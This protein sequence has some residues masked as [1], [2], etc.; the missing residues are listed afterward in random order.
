MAHDIFISYAAQDKA[1]ADAVCNALEGAKMRC[2]I[3]PRDIRSGEHWAESINSAIKVSRV[4]VLIFSKDSNHS[5]QIAKELTLAINSKAIIV[6]FKIDDIVPSGIIEYYLSDTHW[7]D[8][9]N[10]P[11]ESQISNLVET[12]KHALSDKTT[13]ELQKIPEIKFKMGPAASG[14]SKPASDDKKKPAYVNLMIALIGVF[15]V[16]FA[17]YALWNIGRIPE[18]ILEPDDEI[19]N[20]IVRVEGNSAGNLVNGGLAAVQGDI[21]IFRS[22]DGYSLHKGNLV[23]GESRVISADS[24]WFIN[25]SD[26]WIYYSNRDDSNRVYKIKTDGSSRAVLTDGGALFVTYVD[27]WIYYISE[28]DNYGIYRI[29]IDGNGKTLLTEDA[30]EFI[31]VSDGWVYYVNRSEGDKIYRIKVDGSNRE[32]VNETSSCCINVYENDW[33]YYVNKEDGS[34]LY[35]MRIDGRENTVLNDHPTW[36]LNV[37]SGWVYYANENDNFSLN[38]MDLDGNFKMQLSGEPVRFINVVDNWVFY[39]DQKAED[40]VYKVKTDGT[41]RRLAEDSF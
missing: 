27:E 38:R 11:T 22:N 29:S 17:A 25:I 6:P 33:I 37:S 15:I 41:S 18:P 23:D 14:I 9:I 13:E 31:N 1:I 30:A 36:F 2:W 28:A 32:R 16:G 3:A 8:A 4:M 21:I 26:E 35:R 12:V 24:A 7:L 20:G 19:F 40:T 10:P 5:N 39:L 34:K